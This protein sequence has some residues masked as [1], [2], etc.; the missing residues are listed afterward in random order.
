MTNE[1]TFGERVYNGA[2]G[3][4][5]GTFIGES[6]EDPDKVCVLENGTNKVVHLSKTD[7]TTSADDIVFSPEIQEAKAKVYAEKRAMFAA[8]ALNGLLSHHG[9][10]EEKE[11]DV[12]RAISYADIMV[13]KL[14]K[15]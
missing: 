6:Q 10:S 3:D 11:V 12:E 4:Y 9:F 5:I 2:T 15:A 13:K 14:S 1:M 7:I 8:C